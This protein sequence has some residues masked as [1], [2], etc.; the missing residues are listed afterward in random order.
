[1][2]SVN[3][4]AGIFAL[5]MAIAVIAPLL[6]DVAGIPVVA[7]IPL[8]GILL[9][10]QVAGVL[11][12]NI[13]LQFM[14]TI[15]LVYIFFSAGTQFSAEQLRR[16]PKATLLFG[17][18]TFLLPFAVGFIFGYLFFGKN[19]LSA[20]FF[21]AFFASS[22]TMAP[23]LRLR[24]EL[25]ARDSALIA[26]AGSGLAKILVVVILFCVEVLVP[27][28]QTPLSLKTLVFPLVYFIGLGLLLSPLV[29]MVARRTRT[30]GKTDAVFALLAIYASAALAPLAGVPEYMGGFFAGILLAPLL[31]SSKPISNRLDF[32]GESILA[33]FLLVFA[34]VSADFSKV[35][36][37]SLPLLLIG[38]SVVVG[39]GSKFLVAFIAAKLLK[40]DKADRGLLFGFSS[41]FGVFSLAVASVAGSSGLLDQP[42]V[43]GAIV[44][45]IASSLIT[46][47]VS[48]RAATTFN[49]EDNVD[50][51]GDSRGENR[52]LVALSNPA[53]A[54]NLMELG[55]LLHSS[56]PSS[57][58]L[59]CA[60]VSSGESEGESRNFAENMLAAA[61]MQ[62]AASQVSVIPVSKTALNAA[63]GVLESAT[64]QDADTIVVGWNKPPRLSNAFFGSVIE[65]IV[66]SSDRMIFVARLVAPFNMT[67]H[68]IIILPSLCDRHPGFPEALT[69]IS[70]LARKLHARAHLITLK[71]HGKRLAAAFTQ[72]GFPTALL[73]VEIDSW[74]EIGE[75][76][77]KSPSPAKLFILF[78][79]RP[80]EASWHPAVERLP[81]RL[82]EEFP[83][84]NLLL[85]Y[86]AGKGEGQVHQASS[87]LDAE[88]SSSLPEPSTRSRPQLSGILEQAAARGNIRVNMDHSAIADGIF[89]LVASAFP[90]DRKAASRLGSR[91]TEIVQRQ[92]IEIEPGVVLVHD[93]APGIDAPILCLGSK[94]SGFRVSLLDRP[95]KVLILILVPED[96]KPEN[97]LK[98]LGEIA[99]LFKDKDLASRL[100]AADTVQDLFQKKR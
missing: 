7:S 97:H 39:L 3:E 77:K 9:G 32:I 49:A 23:G 100:L 58:L 29:A 59:P 80:S 62:G 20:L 66:S 83:E 96:E 84:A 72:A 69:S 75:G 12:P 78:S 93:R 26:R 89:E 28:F 16:Q 4:P 6:S 68:I 91:L 34:G 54:R 71:G 86:M 67:S 35:P 90:F 95:I 45:L 36:S 56:E 94:R 57:P 99:L 19:V 24:P 13:L 85:V 2:Y 1:M 63:E 38:G 47:W 18:L 21:G 61:I 87:A 52:I 8:F 5:V 60:I 41:S 48:N 22:G 74:K 42:L 53:S 44:L 79:A 37:L 98:L 17:A 33:P 11:E 55:I 70:L 65:Q 14:G 30:Q 46:S 31:T 15:G 10:P 27:I 92:P 88:A 50:T 76:I 43:S 40:Y 25:S 81:H 64:E 51:L 82:G 73:F